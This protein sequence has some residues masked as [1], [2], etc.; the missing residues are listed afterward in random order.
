MEIYELFNSSKM[1]AQLFRNYLA[2][3]KTWHVLVGCAVAAFVLWIP[4]FILQGIGLYTMAKKRGFKK[5]AWAFVPFAN[6][7]YMG[8]LAGNCNFF[9]RKV[10]RAGLY[11]MLA[12]IAVTLVTFSLIAAE[13]YLYIACG[14][15]VYEVVGEGIYQTERR[16]WPNLT[17]FNYG[18]QVYYDF[19]GYIIPIFT[20]I[21]EVLLIVVMMGLLRQYVP[22]NYFILSFLVLFVPLSRFIIIF[23][24]RNRKAIDYEEYVRKQREEFMR[25]QQQYYN[26]YGNPYGN[27][28]GR[29][30]G[31][32]YGNPYNGAP[33]GNPNANPQNTNAPKDE[34]PF[35]EFTSS[36]NNN[37]AGG[38][39]AGDTGNTTSANGENDSDPFF[40]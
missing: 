34:D 27:P 32:G 3:F 18:V 16:Y 28:Y 15:P 37:T 36:N 2:N 1:I 40:N 12:Q 10:K 6:L 4:F 20:L 25:R 39:T 24:V 13:L 8:K 14:D 31:G 11:V 26:Q 22:R 9:A 5:K 19:S 30:Y 21:Y 38:N 23:V 29:P 7:I 17:G 35:A 33:N